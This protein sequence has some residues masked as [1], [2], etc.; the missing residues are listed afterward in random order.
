M[1]SPVP[2]VGLIFTKLGTL[3]TSLGPPV[4][5]LGSL[6]CESNEV[7]RGSVEVIES[8]LREPKKVTW[9]QMRSVWS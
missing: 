7:T 2:Y 6:T 1:G 5:S 9:S 8:P 4:I 3:F